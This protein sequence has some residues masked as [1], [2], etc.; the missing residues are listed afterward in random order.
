MLGITMIED[1][2]GILEG[3]RL[4]MY[5][6]SGKKI[7]GMGKYNEGHETAIEKAKKSK[8]ERTWVKKD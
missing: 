5:T 4:P 8:S 2:N 1:K 7:I 3:K 6:Y